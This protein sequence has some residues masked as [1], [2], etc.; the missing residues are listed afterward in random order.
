MGHG[1]CPITGE[2]NCKCIKNR[3]HVNPLK[4][5]LKAAMRKL[6]TDHAVYTKFTLNSVVD[7]TA[8]VDANTERILQNQVDI[9]QQL[10]PI[11]GRK[12]SKV[13]TELLQEH[14]K[15]AK[16]VIVDATNDD[17]NLNDDVERLFQN[18]DD[19][20]AFLYQ[21]NPEKLPYEVVRK[22]F[23][24]HN[25]H[26]IDMTLARL[27]NEFEK[28]VMLYDSYYNQMLEVSDAIFNAL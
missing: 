24:E 5:D 26:V 7:N 13:L 16:T 10:E 14:I 6:F 18:S 4:V 25:Q 9:G 1:H 11:I 28:E 3:I 8:D 2:V 23:R 15:L 12:N 19:V 22:M 20:A 27:G 21:L 17:P